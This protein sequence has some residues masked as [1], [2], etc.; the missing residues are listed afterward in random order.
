MIRGLS[1]GFAIWVLVSIGIFVYS[2]LNH[3]EKMSVIK[4]A[5]YGLITAVIAAG[6]IA[7][8]VLVF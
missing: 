5:V 2:N 4:C 1:F 6:V 7:G 8:M 3:D